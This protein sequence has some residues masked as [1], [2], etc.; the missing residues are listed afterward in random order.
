M[1][2]YIIISVIFLCGCGEP[3]KPYWKTVC[4]KDYVAFIMIPTTVCSNSCVT[5]MSMQPIIQCE[6]E[7]TQCHI[8]SGY[9]GDP[10]CPP[11]KKEDLKG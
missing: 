6:K 11:I 8:P 4:V 10:V 5:T 1:R 3:T 2:Y 7:Q 9:L